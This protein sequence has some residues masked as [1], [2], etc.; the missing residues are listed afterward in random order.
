MLEACLPLGPCTTSKETFWPSFRVLNPFMLIAE[1]CAKRSSL[2]SSGVIKPKPLES[3]NHL[4]VP[5]AMFATFLQKSNKFPGLPDSLFELNDPVLT[6]IPIQL[7]AKHNGFL[8]PLNYVVNKFRCRTAAIVQQQNKAQWSGYPEIEPH[9]LYC[10]M[11]RSEERR[12]G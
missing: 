1:K 6:A 8:P 4:T 2:P 9:I 10:R 11:K 3:L 7:E 12:V 5:S